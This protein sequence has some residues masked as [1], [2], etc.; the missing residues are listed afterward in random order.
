M[1]R[2]WHLPNPWT[3]RLSPRLES[4]LR[5]IARL[6][7]SINDVVVDN[8][9]ETQGP[10]PKEW[11][12]LRLQ[13]DA[14]TDTVLRYLTNPAVADIWTVECSLAWGH[15]EKR[16]RKVASQSAGLS[17]RRGGGLVRDYP[18]RTG[19]DQCFLTHR[20]I[21]LHQ[22]EIGGSKASILE[23]KNSA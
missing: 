4:S 10:D 17:S 11:R 6:F 3:G 18:E 15:G 12:A 19:T 21:Q 8:R 14:D 13:A 7:N 16:N 20:R 9:Y 1:L 5:Q 23:F 22:M 2:V